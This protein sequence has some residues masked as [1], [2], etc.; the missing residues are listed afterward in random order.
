MKNYMPLDG[1]RCS[2]DSGSAHCDTPKSAVLGRPGGGKFVVL[3]NGNATIVESDLRDYKFFCFNGKVRFF[4]VDFG[5]FV[6]HRANYYLP[7]C[8][9]LPYGEMVCPP[10]PT[11]EIQMPDNL[12]RM[13]ELAEKL[14]AGIPFLRVDLYNVNGRI[15]FGELTFYPAGGLSR[16][17]DDKWDQEIGEMLELDT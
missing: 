2:R 15:Y 9:L 1:L 16:W 14:S 6:E 4:K 13:I 3:D 10:D 5:R 8:K 17:T 7:D 11:A 12:D